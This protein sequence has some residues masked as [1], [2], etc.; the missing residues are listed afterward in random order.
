M[1]LRSTDV[2]PIRFDHRGHA[3][4]DGT[5]DLFPG[6]GSL[7]R[8]DARTPEPIVVPALWEAAG[9][10]DLDGYA[11]YRRTFA[12]DGVPAFA[13]LRFG[14]V[15]DEA[16]VYLNG[17]QIGSHDVPFTPFAFDV[18]GRLREG[19]NEIAVRVFDP[20]V[21]DPVHIR[22]PHGK[23]GWANWVFP[24]RPSLYMTYGGIWQSVELLRHGPVVLEH[25]FVNGDPEDLRAEV[26]VRNVSDAAVDGRLSIRTLGLVDEQPIALEPRASKTVAAWFG[27][28]D[29]PRWTPETPTLHDALADFVL[30]GAPSD[31]C[32]V[33]FG[34]RT[35]RVDGT[36][37]VINETPYRMKSVLV[38]GFR[39]DGL[40]DEGPREEIEREVRA[41]RD[42]G[43]NMV[44]LHIK[45]FHP[46]YLD[47]C[48]ELGMLV[49]CD[50]PIA[51][52]IAHEEIGTGGDLDR[53]CVTAA[54]EQVVRDRNHPSIVL[55]SAMNELCFDRREAR[56]WPNYETFAR[57]ITSTVMEL[58]PTRPVIENDWADPDP[59]RV[60][61][62]PIVTAHWYGRLHAEYL[63]KIER[64][65]AIWRDI[66]R[67][68]YVT[69]F[70]DW[71]LP[72]M[73]LL[74]APPF[75]DTRAVY[76]ADLAASQWPGSVDAFVVETQRYQG[77]SDRLQIEVFRRHGHIGGYC[78]TELTDV[79]RELNGL[80]DLHRNPKE[81]AAAEVRR[82][83]QPVLPML[84]LDSLVS[85]A[86]ARITAAVHVANDGEPLRDVTIE[87]LFGDSAAPVGVDR[88][89]A[90]D[91]SDLPL[92]MILA[93]FDRDPWGADIAELPG[94]RPT[95]IGD[96]TLTAPSVPGSHDLVIRLRARGRLVSENRYPIHVVATTGAVGTVNAADERT[97]EAF[98][99]AGVATD[100]DGVV[101]VAEDALNDGGNDVARRTLV[102]GGT[103]IVLAQRAEALSNAPIAIRGVD[104]QTEWGSSVFHF[105]TDAG[106]TPSLPRRRVLVAE[107]STIHARAAVVEVE[108]ATFPTVPI[109]VAYKPDPGAITGTVVGEHRVGD[110]RLI[111]CQ[112]RLVEPAL[113]GD[114]AARAMLRDLAM[115]A[116]APY[117]VPER[118]TLATVDGRPLYLY[119]FDEDAEGRA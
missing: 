91:T 71:G 48:D 66:G 46:R 86:G 57:L 27:G 15:M 44:R 47:V 94:Y 45:A 116:T 8:L 115:W 5:W 30:D 107:D 108:G 99:A 87:V 53:R 17:E 61:L 98:A 101:V 9:H 24:S 41:A 22:S 77:L 72:T 36:G 88:L 28:I 1:T 51:E 102:D 89:I 56:D 59:D 103:V 69:E 4:L 52:P 79:P 43:F 117:R 114:A 14:A 97:R 96:A 39:A 12:L 58:D 54:H 70:G 42:L 33:R 95:R 35:V 93:R 84:R 64:E 90:T 67:P 21:G 11:W 16:D 100:P 76:A 32:T 109:V 63:E 68:F 38:Q 37:I 60:F 40:Y 106:A 20:P 92:E 7:E 19:E 18:G 26:R 118:E 74:E 112:Y 81:I 110:G 62:S 113:V 13:T 31:T 3:S 49:H 65:S 105:T 78:L 2:R 80:L 75:W 73:P 6:D 104:L 82:A 10:L 55:W 50:L 85:E 25:L 111:F 83:N 34:L 23:Q 29:A 119:A